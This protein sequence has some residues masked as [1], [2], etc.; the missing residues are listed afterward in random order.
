MPVSAQEIIQ[1]NL[2]PFQ[3]AMDAEGITTAF[4]AKKLKAELNAKEI[5]AEVPKGGSGFVYSKPT[6][7]A[8]ALT[9]RQKA[10]KDALAYRGV[11]AA[12]KRQTE[13]DFPKLTERL[14]DEQ[15]DSI[16]GHLERSIAQE[17]P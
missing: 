1:D 10:R 7:T 16:I 14:T 13:I 2:H 15:L 6:Q 8:A 17:T 11:I 9:I 12:E 4:L 3:S 5:L